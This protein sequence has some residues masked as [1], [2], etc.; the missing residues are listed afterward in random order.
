MGDV[1]KQFFHW[2]ATE[3]NPH[4][5]F[6]TFILLFVIYKPP[7][8]VERLQGGA[9]F[10]SRH[11]G[12]SIGIY[13]VH[14]GIG[15]QIVAGAYSNLAKIDHVGESLLLFGVGILKLKYI[16]KENT[17]TTSTTTQASSTTSPGVAQG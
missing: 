2:L 4:L 17:S 15:L 3:A 6:Y 13:F 11:W 12:D 16:P 14:I 5:L 8:I 1:I 7:K 9:D 10:I